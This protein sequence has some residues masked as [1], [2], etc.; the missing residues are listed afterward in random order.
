[1][2]KEVRPKCAYCDRPAE[3]LEYW[4][5][6]GFAEWDEWVCAEHKEAVIERQRAH[7]HHIPEFIPVDE[8]LPRLRR[9]AEVGDHY[10]RRLLGWE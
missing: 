5:D 1:M 2:A 8:A 7:R 4:D 6:C 3:Y 9:R 10:A